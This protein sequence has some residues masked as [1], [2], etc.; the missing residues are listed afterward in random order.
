MCKEAGVKVGCGGGGFGVA[1]LLARDRLASV[2][3][4]EAD[5]VAQMGVQAA[6]R[7]ARIPV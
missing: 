2:D 1:Y 3:T 5:R 6:R 4:W 7:R